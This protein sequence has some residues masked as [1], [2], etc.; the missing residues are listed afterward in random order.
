MYYCT[1]EFVQLF[2]VIGFGWAMDNLWPIVTSLILPAVR[3]EF[4]P[5]RAPV[6]IYIIRFILSLELISHS[7][8]HSLKTSVFFSVQSS[9]VSAAI[10]LAAASLSM[11]L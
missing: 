2:I 3:S 4:H 5:T 8:S 11:R 6:C 7:S 10:S 9:G 1:D